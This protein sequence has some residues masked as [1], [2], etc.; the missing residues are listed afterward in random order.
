[1]VK[2]SVRESARIFFCIVV[3]TTVTKVV[4]EITDILQ[5]FI[6]FVKIE[7]CELPSCRE[8]QRLPLTSSDFGLLVTPYSY[9]SL[10]P[11]N[12]LTKTIHL[13]ISLLPEIQM[14]LASISL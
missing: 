11:C 6:I 13:F 7:K 8:I 2:I 1:M 10:L 5:S 4:D 3:E 9:T 12:D 14:V